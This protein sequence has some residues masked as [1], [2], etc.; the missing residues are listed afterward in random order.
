MESHCDLTLADIKPYPD[1]R[2]IKHVDM[3]H[4][5]QVRDAMRGMDAVMEFYGE[6]SR[7]HLELSRQ[8]TGRIACHES[9][10]RIGHQKSGAYGTAT[11]EELLRSG[12]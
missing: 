7:P 8:Y 12:F 3:R 9:R 1:G 2:P 6:P 5:D 10:G 11:G 4:Y